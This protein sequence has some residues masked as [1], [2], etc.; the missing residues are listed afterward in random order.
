[1]VKEA[2]FE[3]D[4]AFGEVEKEREVARERGGERDNVYCARWLEHVFGVPREHVFRV[5]LQ[6]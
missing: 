1:V 4:G 3:V 5:C 2:V 6:S